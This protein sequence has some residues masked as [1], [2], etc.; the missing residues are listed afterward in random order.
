MTGCCLSH[1]KYT[2]ELDR[3]TLPNEGGRTILEW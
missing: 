1:S 2:W 3:D